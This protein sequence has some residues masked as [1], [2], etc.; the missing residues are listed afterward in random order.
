MGY[1]YE[2]HL[3]YISCQLLTDHFARSSDTGYCNYSQY[4]GGN[5]RGL[6]NKLDYIKGSYH[7]YH[8]T[9][10]YN[11]NYHFGSEEDFKELIRICHSEES[12]YLIE[13]NIIMIGV[14]LITGT[15]NRKSKIVVYAVYQI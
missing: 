2:Y 1:C 11:L 8:F 14:K 10:L 5:Y 3:T 15:I 9:N 6:I 7:G 4:C 12:T 13:L